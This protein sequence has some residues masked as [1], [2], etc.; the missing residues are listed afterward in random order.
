[1]TQA[2][3]IMGITF[4]KRTL[5]ET[6]QEISEVVGQN[7]SELCH[8][9]TGNPEI[10]MACQHDKE[11]RTIVEE[12]G[13]VTADGIG[14]VMVSKVRGG[15]LPERVTGCDLLFKLLEGNADSMQKWTFY[16]L[17]ADEETSKKAVEVIT[18]KYPNVTIVGRHHG[19]FKPEEDQAIVDEIGSLAPDFLIV[20]LGAPRA[21]RWIYKYKH[22]LNARVAI[23]VGGSLDVVAGKVKRAPKMWQ[24]LHMEWLYRLLKQP[25]RWRRQL[26]LPRFALK[27]VFYKK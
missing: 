12:A 3:Q 18:Q 7:R 21:E 2:T 17:G 11:L 24:K 1:M 13:L 5:D 10:V 25:S 6:I 23:G 19:Y 8:V 9:V 22:E 15:S 16:L 4:P 27:A 20:A 14:I 26:I